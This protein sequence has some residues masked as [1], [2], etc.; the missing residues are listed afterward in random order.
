MKGFTTT[1]AIT[2]FLAFLAPPILKAVLGARSL[3]ATATA[4]RVAAF[5]TIIIFTYE[6]IM[7]DCVQ[8]TLPL[9]LWIIGFL[10]FLAQGETSIK[11][12]P[13]K[14]VPLTL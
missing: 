1:I 6:G 7:L 2:S 8:R 11:A 12:N 10:A 9:P 14:I 4:W 3:F 5:D 13:T